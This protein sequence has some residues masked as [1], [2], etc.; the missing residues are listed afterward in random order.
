MND[1]WK[2]QYKL[3]SIEKIENTSEG[4]LVFMIEYSRYRYNGNVA[5]TELIQFS[6]Y[7]EYFTDIPLMFMYKVDMFNHFKLKEFYNDNS[8]EDYAKV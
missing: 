2:E 8:T 1:F 6:A 5:E 7:P 4:I 3:K